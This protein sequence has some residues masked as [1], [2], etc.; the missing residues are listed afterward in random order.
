MTRLPITI[1][2]RRLGN[3]LGSI[4]Y[5]RLCCPHVCSWNLPGMDR[6][7]MRKKTSESILAYCWS[8]YG[9]LD[10][11]TFEKCLEVEGYHKLKRQEEER[12]LYHKPDDHLDMNTWG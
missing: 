2:Q 7:D 9:D 10:D 1:K 3:E 6:S 4:L 5:G 11:E 8:I 12:S